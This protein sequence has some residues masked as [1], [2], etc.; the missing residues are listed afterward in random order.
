MNW[1]P[2]VKYGVIGVGFIATAI[3]EMMDNNEK[4]AKMKDYA[5]EAV[6]EFMSEQAKES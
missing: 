6:K 5:K 3:K 1:K 2:I 4:D